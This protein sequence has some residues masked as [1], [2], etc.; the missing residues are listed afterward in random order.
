MSTFLTGVYLFQCVI[1]FCLAILF[2]LHLLNEL[3][4][5]LFDE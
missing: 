2:C 5:Q 3:N 4:V 1:G